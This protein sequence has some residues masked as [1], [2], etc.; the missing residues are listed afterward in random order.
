MRGDFSFTYP[1]F[2]ERSYI[3]LGRAILGYV[4]GG[5]MYAVVRAGGKQYR[6]EQGALVTVDRIPGDPGSTITLDD[7]LM[8]ADG[9]EITPAPQGATVTAEIVDQGKGEK[10]KVLRYKNKV[11]YR[12][13]TGHRSKQTTLRI[14]RIEG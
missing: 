7:V 13:L 4:L 8:L 6:V 9:E 1:E 3:Q 5:S 12:K 2:A 10:I 14:T 11:R